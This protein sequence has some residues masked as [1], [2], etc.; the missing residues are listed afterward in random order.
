MDY[1]GTTLKTETVEQGQS[2]TAPADPTREGYSFTG[3]SPSNFAAVKADMSITAQYERIV[4]YYWVYF[5]DNDEDWNYLG[6]SKVEQGTAAI[7][8]L[9]PQLEGFIFEGWDK[10]I[11]NVTGYMDVF[12]VFRPALVHTV[13]RV[14]SATGT[15]LQSVDKVLSANMRDSLDGE[16]T[17]DFSTLTNRSEQI[18]TGCVVEY[19]N[20]FFNVVRVGKNITNGMM[21]TDRKSVV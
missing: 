4:V 16:L 6:S 10:D 17:F 3:W 18:T 9:P 19:E 12:A 8:P 5:Y 2:A 1:D 20:C 13:L 11:S 14:Y 21:V 7:P 15:L